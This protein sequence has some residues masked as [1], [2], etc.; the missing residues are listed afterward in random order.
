MGAV[1]NGEYYYAP[2]RSSWG[3]W[4]WFWNGEFGHG[5]FFKDYDTRE[6]ARKAVYEL[7]GWSYKT[8]KNLK[9]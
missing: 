8:N 1:K 6:E 2:H 5:E 7:N 3:V 9:Q 4:R